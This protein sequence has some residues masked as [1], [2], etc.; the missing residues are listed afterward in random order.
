LLTDVDIE[1]IV[2]DRVELRLELVVETEFEELR[3]PPPPPNQGL[4]A[5]ILGA[6]LTLS[7]IDPG[8][9]AEGNVLTRNEG[10]VPDLD[11]VDAEDENEIVGVVE[12]VP[13]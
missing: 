12:R 2:R 10:R 8:L 7:P 1:E 3:E 4:N 6:C 13:P 5:P 9:D 11:P